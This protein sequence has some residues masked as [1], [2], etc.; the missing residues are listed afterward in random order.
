MSEKTEQPTAKKLREAR[1]KGEVAYSKDFTQTILILVIFGYFLGNGA[2]IVEDMGKLIAL[3][4]AAHDLPFEMALDIVGRE[5]LSLSLRI[6]APL[7]VIVI[8]VGIF[9]DMMQVGVTLAFKALMP[10]AKKLNVLANAKNMVSK[11]NLVEFAKSIVK[12]VFL[13]VLIY[14]VVRSSLDGLMRV[15]PS[16]LPG[17]MGVLGKLVGQVMAYTAVAY[18][19]VAAFDFAFQR[20]NHTK[21]L[22]MS[23][24]EVKREYKEMEG[25]PH[26]KGKRKQ[27]H[28][29]M[30]TTNMVEKTR[31]ASVVVTNPTHIA[32]ALYYDKDET[33]LPVVLAKAENLIAKRIVEIAKEEGIPIMRNVPLA[34]ALFEEAEIDQYVPSDLLEPVAEVLRWVQQLEQE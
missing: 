17:V 7:L 22:M 26:I 34:R 3:P 21:Q 18:I 19:V 30:M 1:E 28:Q 9:A 16:G 11:K 20:F 12:V 6:L 25:D 13:S 32:V 2:N 33:P 15:P 31:K 8:A 10:S 27:L 14:L 29:E 5:V 23:K 24:D 4:G